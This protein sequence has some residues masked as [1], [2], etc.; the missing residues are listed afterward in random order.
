MRHRF[1]VAVWSTAMI[2]W[3]VLCAVGW[4]VATRGDY[5]RLAAARACY[6]TEAKLQNVSAQCAGIKPSDIPLYRA[7]VDRKATISR[8]GAAFGCM[9]LVISL[10]VTRRAGTRNP[11]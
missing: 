8:L 11:A 9:V 7:A 10:I 3:C 2:F 1:L 6:P 5:A 4:T